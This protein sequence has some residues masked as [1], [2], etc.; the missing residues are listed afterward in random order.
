MRLVPRPWT[1]GMSRAAA[2]VHFLVWRHSAWGATGAVFSILL[3]ALVLV[4]CQ[5]SDGFQGEFVGAC[6]SSTL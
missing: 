2:I 6:T 4:A 3:A 1:P 5:A